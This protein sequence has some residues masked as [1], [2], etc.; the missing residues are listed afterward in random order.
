MNAGAFV[1]PFNTLKS[2]NL[3]TAVGPSKEVQDF[4]SEA[5]TKGGEHSQKVKAPPFGSA[6]GSKDCAYLPDPTAVSR[7]KEATKGLHP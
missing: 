2:L 6:S 5:I 1:N 3:E 7:I 4:E